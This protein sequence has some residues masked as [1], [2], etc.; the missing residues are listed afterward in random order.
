M[1]LNEAEGVQYELLFCHLTFQYL[2]SVSRIDC[3]THEPSLHV[4]RNGATVSA[5]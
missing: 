3:T 4:N 5:S 1:I 2:L